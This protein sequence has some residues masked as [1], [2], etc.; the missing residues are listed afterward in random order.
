MNNERVDYCNQ[1]LNSNVVMLGNLDKNLTV[2]DSSYDT[3]VC[4]EV[5]EHL[6]DPAEGLYKLA[7]ITKKRLIITVPYNEQIRQVLCIHCAKYTPYSGHLHSFNERNMVDI[8][9]DSSKII[10]IDLLGNKV[11]GYFPGS[12]LLFK[13]PLFISRSIDRVLNF[14]FRRARWMVVV[15]DKI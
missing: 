4:M 9:P 8:I 7:R 6:D 14:I 13:L 10:K 12:I 2:E 3:V 5:L 1:R 11:L 15:I